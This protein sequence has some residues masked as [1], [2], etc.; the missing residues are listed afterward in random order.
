MKPE[1]ILFPK[2]QNSLDFLLWKMVPKLV[3]EAYHYVI[4]LIAKYC[5][6]YYF[7]NE[8]HTK[9]VFMRCSYLALKEGI[10]PM[11]TEDL[12]IA[13]LFHDMWFLEQYAKNEY[14]GSQ[15]ARKWLEKKWHPEDRIQK[16][17]A[18]IM[19]TVVFSKPKTRLEM[20]MQD[21]DLDNIWTENAFEN[22]VRLEKELREIAEIKII[23]CSY[24]EYAYHIYSDFHFNT[25]TAKAERNE[26]RLKNIE[27]ISQYLADFPNCEIPEDLN[28][29]AKII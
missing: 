21:A 9:N 11:D 3:Y 13:A 4:P 24:W 12:Q 16:I 2:N 15:M 7:H 23:G 8:R 28:Y 20:I 22:S 25:A 29:M 14:I 5:G 19:S 10:W 6:N 27:K 1:K 17:E 26:T 18:I